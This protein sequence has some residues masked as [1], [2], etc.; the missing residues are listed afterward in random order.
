[1]PHLFEYSEKLQKILQKLSKKDGKRYEIIW[2]KIN[3]IINSENIEHYKN[4]RHPLNNFKA[5]HIDK[6]FVLIFRFDKNKN[7]ISFEDF[8][9][10][11]KVYLKKY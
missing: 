6:S 1:M 2:K 9:H 8:D 7:L 11:D 5:V 4:L 10:H 3:E